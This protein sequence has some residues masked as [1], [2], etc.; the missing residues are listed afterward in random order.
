MIK[1][2]T[3]CDIPKHSLLWN[4]LKSY[5][6]YDSFSREFQTTEDI[7]TL[8]KKLFETPRWVNFLI[9]LRDKLVRPFGLKTSQEIDEKSTGD[10]PFQVLDCTADELLMY[11]ADKHLKMWVSVQKKGK[12]VHLTTVVKYNMLLGRIYF[13]FIKPFHIIIIRSLLKRLH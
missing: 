8:T 9:K 13:F 6:Y 2:S 11:E 4:V 3:I 7:R 5:N 12:S 1:V 10:M